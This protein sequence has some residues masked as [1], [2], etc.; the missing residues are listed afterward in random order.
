MQVCGHAE[1]VIAF[2]ALCQLQLRVHTFTV[3]EEGKE[4]TMKNITPRYAA[5]A[6]NSAPLPLIPGA[7]AAV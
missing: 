5:R 4:T 1:Y 6:Q 2:A 3:L 7:Y